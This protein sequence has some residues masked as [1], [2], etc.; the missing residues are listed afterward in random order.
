MIQILGGDTRKLSE[1]AIKSHVKELALCLGTARPFYLDFVRE[2]PGRMVET[3]R[4][5]VSV[6][7]IAYA[8]ATRRRLSFIPVARSGGDA[9]H[10]SQTVAAATGHPRGIA[11]RHPILRGA[12]PAGA[13]PTAPVSRMAADSQLPHNKIDL[14]LDLGCL[15]PDTELPPERLERIVRR[16]LDLGEWRRVVVVGS[17]MPKSLTDIKEDTI[18]LIERTEWI[19]WAGLPA[20][21]RRLVAFGD[22]GV[23]H[24]DPPQDAGQAMGMRANIRYAIADNHLVARAKGA[25]NQ[26]GVHQYRSLC[27]RLQQRP[28]FEGRGASCGDDTIV[29]CAE[30]RIP[31][32][33]QN[34]WRQA[35]TA[36][37]L[38]FVSA[39]ALA[40][41]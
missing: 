31:P 32:R 26:E 30:G 3:K 22:Y 13:D 39:Q 38:T 36:R 10:L 12:A 17:S 21:L 27:Q 24:P 34:M 7:E 33:H 28:E 25:V 23:Q 19:A 5:S 6:A 9:G 15:G 8:A 11:I 18:G 37:H 20:E 2:D 14:L 40:L 41:R 1:G 4:G 29:D 16:Y 35:G